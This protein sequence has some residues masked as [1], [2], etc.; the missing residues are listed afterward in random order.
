M[1]GK[2]VA[3]IVIFTLIILFTTLYVT[4]A[5]GYY[6][7]S[8]KK[9]N[10]LTEEAAK[11][12]EKD[13]EIEAGNIIGVIDE[14]RYFY[15]YLE[16]LLFNKPVITVDS[17]KLNKTE[18]R[19]FRKKISF[20]ESYICD[21]YLNL[22]VY[23]Y[24]KYSLINQFLVIKDY[25]KKI[26]D[27]LKIVGLDSK[28]LNKKIS[29]LSLSEQRL[30]LFAISLLSNPNMI[31]FD[32]FFEGLDLKTTKFVINILNQL[33]EQ[34]NKTFFIRCCDVDDIYALTKK[35]IIFEKNEFFVGGDTIEVFDDYIEILIKN[36]L[37]IPKTVMFTYRANSL[38]NAKLGYFKDIRDLIKD[39]YKK[40]K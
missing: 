11:K 30:V 21:D 8:N 28:Y 12:F 39:I 40:V 29:L 16:N 35:V 9:I 33:A 2:N 20:V 7:Y 36:G 22:S 32:N 26:K 27:S 6:E 18:T 31:V 37:P 19:A 24:M 5:F 1:K 25:N 15:N 13:I 4:Q 23:E 34:Y 38:K 14:D 17:K 3:R 10:T